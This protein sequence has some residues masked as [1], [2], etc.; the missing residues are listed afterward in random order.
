MDL[1]RANSQD[2]Q[3]GHLRERYL[4]G[5]AV[6]LTFKGLANAQPGR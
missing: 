2:T 1:Q 3:I 5:R 6:E 4:W